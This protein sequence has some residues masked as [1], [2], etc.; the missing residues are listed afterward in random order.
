MTVNKQ[1]SK[2]TPSMCIY[3]PHFL[4]SCPNPMLLI[5][6]FSQVSV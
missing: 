1:K 5:T 4:K 3:L 6:V 2:M